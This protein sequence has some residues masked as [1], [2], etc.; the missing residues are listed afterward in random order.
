MVPA[1][2]VQEE[3]TDGMGEARLRPAGDPG[4][5][6]SFPLPR[7]LPEPRALE[8]TP[9]GRVPPRLCKPSLY[10]SPRLCRRWHYVPFDIHIRLFSRH[11]GT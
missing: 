10:R 11:D 3:P 8:V 5:A 4:P 2:W 9:H 6:D 7:P 1:L